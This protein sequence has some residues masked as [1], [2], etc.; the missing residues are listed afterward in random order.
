MT[1]VVAT[2]EFATWYQNLSE[3]HQASVARIVDLLEVRGVSLPF[4]YSSQIKGSSRALRELR[5][6]AQGAEIRIAYAFDPKRQAV[7]LIA[8]DKVGNDR[9]YEW[10]IPTAEKI[11]IRYLEEQQ[12][13]RGKS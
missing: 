13:K 9:F 12:G 7:L 10:L 4:P 3:E 1:E 2:D 8:G 11:W 5:V 6:K